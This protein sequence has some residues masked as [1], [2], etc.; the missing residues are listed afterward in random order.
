MEEATAEVTPKVSVTASENVLPGSYAWR[1]YFART[2]DNSLVMGLIAAVLVIVSGIAVVLVNPQ[3]GLSYLRWIAGGGLLQRTLMGFIS[4]LLWLPIEA[5]FLSAVGATPGK[6][7]FGIRVRTQTGDLLGYGTSISR[8]TLVTIK[9]LALGIPLASLA[10]LMVSYD[11]LVKKGTMS[12]DDDKK[13]TVSYDKLT[14]LR[15]FFCVITVILWAV[16]AGWAYIQF[17]AKL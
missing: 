1:R 10:T 8:A 5:L 9:G 11:H 2:V 17:L 7:I 15:I 12:W 6:W 4:M 13:T 14:D 3:A 16:V